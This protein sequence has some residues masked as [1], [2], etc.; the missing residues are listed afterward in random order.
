MV[1]FPDLTSK[2]SILKRGLS[3]IDNSISLF[4]NFNFILL[5]FYD[6]ELCIGNYLNGVK[7]GITKAFTIHHY[8]SQNEDKCWSD[9]YDVKNNYFMPKWKDFLPIKCNKEQKNILLLTATVNYDNLQIVSESIYENLSKNQDINFV[10]CIC[11]DVN[12]TGDFDK[13]LKK[14]EE[15]GI[16]VITFDTGIIGQKTYGGGIYNEVLK[17]LKSCYYY[18]IDPWIYILDDDN[19]IC[20]L[21]ASQLDLMINA[22]ETVNKRAIWMSMHR[23]DGFID[24]VRSYSIYG[25]GKNNNITYA[26]EFMPDPSQLLLKLSLIEEFGYFDEGYTYDQKLW[27]YFYEHTG[28]IILPEQWHEGHWNGRGNNNFYQCYHDGISDENSINIVKQDIENNAPLSFSLIV[29]RNESCE[30]FL[31]NR[32][33]GIETFNKMK[34]KNKY[35]YSILT[36]IFND[37]ETLKDIQDYRDDVEYVCVTDNPNLTSDKWKIVQCWDVMKRLPLT[38]QFAYVRFHP[39]QFVESDIC[40][41]IDASEEIKKDFYDNLILPFINKGY[42]YGATLHYSRSD[43]YDEINAWKDIRGYNDGCYEKCIKFLQ[44]EN[45]HTQGMVDGGLII[46]TDTKTCHTINDMTWELC[47]EL[48]VDTEI[49]RNFQ[50]DLAYILNKYYEN[51]SEI[52]LIHPYIFE[53]N[54]IRRYTHNG[55]YWI[56]YNSKETCPCMFW[57][58]KISPFILN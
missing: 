16:E 25:K 26:D 36:C 41:T 4:G 55:I 9:W 3:L 34:S 49:D 12:G 8:K 15:Y 1:S 44:D 50:I 39:F 31:L 42:K 48:T 18:Y 28:D 27:Q 38:N 51:S 53:S 54:Y 58:H 32:Q 13:V 7:I 22:A 43:I 5:H 11:K 56:E 21:M 23:E 2:R 14:C 37:Y 40:I 33:E 45:Y 47:H 17:L 46:H 19:L 24:T 10:W 57:N 29:G 30:R 35:K 6:I 52:M 20:P